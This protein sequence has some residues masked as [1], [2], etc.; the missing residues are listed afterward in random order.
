MYARLRAGGGYF[1]RAVVLDEK[2]P[3]FNPGNAIAVVESCLAETPATGFLL[4]RKAFA[5]N[6]RDR[7][8]RKLQIIDHEAREPLSALGWRSN[9]LAKKR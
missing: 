1:E 2:V 6:I 3:R 8:M 4:K 7:E 9:S 5:G